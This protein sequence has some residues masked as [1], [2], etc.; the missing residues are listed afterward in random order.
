MR[1]KESLSVSILVWGTNTKKT[2]HYLHYSS[3]KIISQK[4]HAKH[5]ARFSFLSLVKLIQYTDMIYESYKLDHPTKQTEKMK[6]VSTAT[7]CI[8][9]FCWFTTFG[10][11][12][13]RGWIFWM[14]GMVATATA[15]LGS[16]ASH[17]RPLSWLQS[18][19]PAGQGPDH[20]HHNQLP[21]PRRKP[22]SPTWEWNLCMEEE[23]DRRRRRRSG[24][25]Q[26]NQ[27]PLTLSWKWSQVTKVSR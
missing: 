17:P 6:C 21:R 13:Y 1:K 23:K 19:P 3:R 25:C 11:D 18:F 5:A 7:W 26:G 4:F 24:C 9:A 2:S 10:L 16:P 14:L 22:H 15:S 8:V 27:F 12:L 20:H